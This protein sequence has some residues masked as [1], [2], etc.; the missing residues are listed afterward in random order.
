[1][2]RQY[3]R[4]HFLWHELLLTGIWGI[5]IWCALDYL[6]YR[7]F[8]ALWFSGIWLT[9]YYYWSGKQR[10]SR[11]KKELHYHFKDVLTSMQTAVQAGYAVENALMETEQ[12]LL[13][14]YG[15]K[16]W[17]A[18]ELKYMRKQMRLGV[19]VEKLFL[20][21]GERCQIEDIRNFAEVLAI[22][23]RAGGNMTLLMENAVRIL[24]DKIE[25]QKEIESAVAAKKYEQTIMSIVPAV[26]ILY[27]QVSFP[28]FLD[29]L[30]NTVM[31]TVIMSVCL[32]IYG[33]S[34]YAG[35]KIVEI[36]V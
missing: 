1:M 10:L 34:W 6:F 32:V 8:K 11:R 28:G 36:E 24:G 30:Y 3:R 4:Y 29:V 14:R 23:K 27:M 26:I 20:D 2:K 7:S 13:M 16:D 9:C 35:R 12:D 22:G 17:M 15:A 19:P 18:G 33:V 21:F 25:T 31:G 5:A